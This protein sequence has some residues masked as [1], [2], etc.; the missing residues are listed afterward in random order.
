MKNDMKFWI[1]EMAGSREALGQGAVLSLYDFRMLR[2]A[3]VG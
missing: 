2:V 1:Y 3:D